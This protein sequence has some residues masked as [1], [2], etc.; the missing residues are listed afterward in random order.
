MWGEAIDFLLPPRCVVSGVPVER[1]G[2][3][4]PEIW[5]ELNFVSDPACKR[6]GL[7]FEFNMEADIC[8]A[9]LD[10]PPVFDKARAA[11]R[12]DDGSRSVVL[13]FKHGDQLHAVKAFTPWLQKAG[14]GL[15]RRADIIA[16]VPLHYW[17]LVR[18]RYNQS[19]LMA[20]DLARES[21]KTYIP[22]LLLRTRATPPQ[23]HLKAGER[24]A[25]VRKAFA[26]GEHK[27]KDRNILLIDD[28]MTSGATANEC[29]SVL[30]KAGAN[31]VDVLTL[32]RVVKS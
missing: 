29:A 26:L 14:A 28:V 7:P 8:A 22:D 21:E 1:Q 25:N 32:A 27:V 6:C 9:C 5:G 15:I 13:G 20:K 10:H 2:M 11:L 19:A 4:S 24:A 17:R 31:R 18:R 3:I 12:Y 30:K 23:G 16:P